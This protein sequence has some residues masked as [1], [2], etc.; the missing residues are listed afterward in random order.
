MKEL[1]PYYKSIFKLALPVIISQV[2]GMTVGLADTIMVGQLGDTQLA[3][4]A[5]SNSLSWVIFMF[6]MGLAMGL[7]PLVGRA[8]ARK[9]NKRMGSLLKNALYVNVALGV[10]FT[11]VI[12]C[13]SL[14]MHKMGQDPAI[15]FDA[16]KYIMFQVMS[17]LPIMIFSTFKQFLEGIGNTTYSMVITVSANLINIFLNYL[18]IYGKWGFP[19]MGAA[20][21]GAS[22][23]ISRIYMVVLFLI[24]MLKKEQYRQYLRYAY[25]STISKFRMRRLLNVGVPIAGQ[26]SIEM[27]AI[28]LMA[29]AIGTLGATSLAGHQVAIN[30]PSLSFMVVTGLASATTI[31]VSQNYGLRLF[32]QIRKTLTAA[33]HIVLAYMILSSIVIMSLATPIS[34]IFT[35]DPAVVKIAAY[36]LLF[37]SAFQISD[38][39]QGIILGALRGLMVVKR[40]MFYAIGTYIFVGTPVGY[41]CAFVLGMGPSG[42]WVAFI[43]CLTLLAVFYTK[44]YKNAMKKLEQP[45]SKQ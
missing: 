9:D 18:L 1:V 37:G 33:M 16:R 3:A 35:T 36:L 41:L 11:L 5:F 23:F 25:K 31:I 26:L 13:L 2:G 7:T 27:G 28:S 12:L 19:E 10:V 30:I 17:A 42:V 14:L 38:G 43:V 6:G 40:P 29:I 34:Q 39:V 4:V 20:G 21:A 15:L 44:S 24:L 22:T 32:G 8:Y 45:S